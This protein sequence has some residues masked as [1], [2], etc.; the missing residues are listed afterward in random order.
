[1][2]QHRKLKKENYTSALQMLDKLHPHKVYLYIAL[3]CTSF[4]LFSM[5]IAYTVSRPEGIIK[6]EYS[7]PKTFVLAGFLLMV[8]VYAVSR[9]LMLYKKDD[10]KSVSKYLGL[11][12]GFMLIF[13]AL[14]LAGYQ[15]LEQMGVFASE[16]ASNSYLTVIAVLHAICLISNLVVLLMAYFKTLRVS[17][18][19]V[20]TLIMVT[21]PYEK[22]KLEMVVA[23][24]FYMTACWSLIFF[25]FLF[26]Y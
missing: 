16:T 3:L 26:M 4:I 20:K 18:D 25:F 24:T 7:T 12:L 1:M 8:A 17:R 15:Q 9:V 23:F 5:L 21:T 19:V 10:L 6:L 22:I 13:G 14:Q 2:E 11:A